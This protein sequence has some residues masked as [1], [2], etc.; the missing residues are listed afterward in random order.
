MSRKNQIGSR[1]M[2]RKNKE[3]N[4]VLRNLKNHRV[5]S[6]DMPR[7]ILVLK[8]SNENCRGATTIVR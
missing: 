8:D 7:V 6:T 3:E 2:G 5:H 4:N 1:V